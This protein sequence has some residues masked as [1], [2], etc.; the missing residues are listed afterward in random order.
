MALLSMGDNE[1]R[2]VIAV[3]L[4]PGRADNNTIFCGES[5][6]ANPAQH[7][8]SRHQIRATIVREATTMVAL[9][10][11]SSE[12]ATRVVAM[13]TFPHHFTPRQNTHHTITDFLPAI[14]YIAIF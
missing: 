8:I 2:G 14:V 4:L 13:L 7:R 12:R 9:A 11:A 6:L 1:F 3:R 5:R 10:F